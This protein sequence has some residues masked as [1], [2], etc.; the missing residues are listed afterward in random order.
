[1]KKVIAILLASSAVLVV[2][3]VANAHEN[4]WQRESRQYGN[5]GQELDHLYDGVEHGLSDGSYSRGQARY[6]YRAINSVRRRLDAYQEND[7]YLNRWEAQ[8]IQNRLESL[9]QDMHQ[10]HAEGHQEQNYGYRNGGYR[11]NGGDGY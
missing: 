7:G 5:F 10:A 11:Y 6:Y 4:D 1:M 3:A 2:P 8:D 9:H